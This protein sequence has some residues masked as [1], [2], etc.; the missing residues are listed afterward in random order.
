MRP[1][2]SCYLGRLVVDIVNMPIIYL[3]YRADLQAMF[4]DVWNGD[5]L[6]FTDGSLK[7]LCN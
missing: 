7:D 4:V 2:Q 5:L 1:G 6:I 3:I